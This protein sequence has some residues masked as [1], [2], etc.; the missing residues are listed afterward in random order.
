[1]TDRADAA[2]ARGLATTDAPLYFLPADLATSTEAPRD[3]VGA[4]LRFQREAA[5]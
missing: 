1:V 3:G 2:L 5:I 4:A